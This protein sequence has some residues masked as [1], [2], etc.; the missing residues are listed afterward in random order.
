ME[1]KGYNISNA[2]VSQA[3]GQGWE[4]WLNLIDGWGGSEMTHTEIARQLVEAGHIEVGNEWWAQSVTVGYEYARGRRIK[5]ETKDAGF[6]VGV[7]KTLTLD[8]DS[9]WAFLFTTEGLSIWLGE[10]ENPLNLESG[11]AYITA[12]G[13]VGEIRTVYPGEKI[14][15]TWQPDDWPE[16]STLQLYLLN[17]GDKTSL[18]FHHEKLIDADQRAAMKAH[19]QAVLKELTKAISSQ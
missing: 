7:Q 15:L 9:L 13:T 12:D 4:E 1:I 19:W 17:N 3:T 5:G 14:R 16:P 11:S 2:A 8:A 6:Q 18:R 10:T